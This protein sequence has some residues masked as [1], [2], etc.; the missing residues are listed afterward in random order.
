MWALTIRAIFE[1]LPKPEG[2]IQTDYTILGGT[3][4]LKAH[5][6]KQA[7]NVV[8]KKSSAFETFFRIQR[9]FLHWLAIGGFQCPE[10]RS[11]LEK[12]L[13]ATNSCSPVIHTWAKLV[14]V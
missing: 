8:F 1:H 13:E 6:R 10:M 12:E 7:D 11:A 5:A 2:Q 9:S 4:S 3:D 14:L